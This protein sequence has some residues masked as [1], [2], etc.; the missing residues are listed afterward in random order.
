MLTSDATLLHRLR[1][2]AVTGIAITGSLL[3]SGCGVGTPA[4]PAEAPTSL[5]M[6]G[7]VHGGQSPVT[8]SHIG[9]F[10]TANSGTSNA[11]YGKSATLLATTS[12]DSNGNFSITSSYTCPS[13]QQ[14]YLVASGGNPGTTP[15]TDNSAIFMVAAL[16]PCSGIGSVGTIDIDE[17]TTVAA[18]YAL[19]GFLPAGGAGMTESALTGTSVNGTMAGITTSAANTQGLSD[20][21]AN[22]GNIVSINTGLAY[23]APPSNTSGVVPQATIHALADILQNCANSAGPASSYC[24][25]LFAAA[26]PPTGSGVSA[27]VNVLQAAI[28]IAT[29]P[30]NNAST[31]FGLLS[32]SPAFPTTL[33]AAPND[34]TIGVTYNYSSSVLVS[35][36][37]LGID[38]YDNVYVTGSTAATTGTD[39]LLMSAQGALLNSALMPTTLTSNNIRYIAFDSSN[40]AYMSNG[41]ATSIFKFAPTTANN[42]SAGGT[43]STLSYAG[44]SATA[45]N[46]G[47]AVDAHGNVWTQGYKAKTCAGAPST[48]NLVSC[49]LV[50]FGN[51]VSSSTTPVVAWPSLQDLQP[52]LGGARGLA[53]DTKTGNIWTT[54][55]YNSNLTIFNVG[56]SATPTATTAANSTIMNVAA[57]NTPGTGTQGVAI[58]ANSNAWVTLTGTGLAT[59]TVPGVLYKVTPALSATVIPSP[60]SG[61]LEEPGYNVIDGNGN[62]FVAINTGGGGTGRVG[63]V[64]EYSPTFNSNA[65]AWLAPGIGY[66]P[67]SFYTGAGAGAT[68][69]AGAPS[70][71]S[72]SSITVGV[73]GS[74]YT[75]APGVVLTSGSCTTEPTATATVSGGA[76]TGFTVTSGGVGCTS[77]PTVTVATLYGGPIYEPSYLAVDKSGAVWTLSSGSNGATSLANLVQILGVAAPTDPNQAD[78]NYGVKP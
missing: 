7:H 62:V 70:G 49:S 21:F 63:A 45:N 55:I 6:T 35:G 5:N 69:T 33:A 54:D 42:P 11:G 16:G 56:T 43:V 4:G 14:A 46:W 72:I 47:V 27:P 66:S 3:I 9:L 53:F 28:D 40:S 22:A 78:G 25:S 15:G 76:V 10:A 29:Y 73:G 50:E 13:T 68:G 34:W 58:D 8:Q 18:A 75:T 61:N 52:G 24:V 77:A 38:N 37:G 57:N 71:G 26:T 12:S 2:F 1:L 20:A 59:T 31:L 51:P 23:T 60:A 32:T 19:S 36:I 39:L 17:V 67:S 65:G 30:G 48:S 44:V 41:S 64:E 74:G